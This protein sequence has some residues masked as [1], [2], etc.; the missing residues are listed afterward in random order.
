MSCDSIF[1]GLSINQDHKTVSGSKMSGILEFVQRFTHCWIEL[2][3]F[4]CSNASQTEV[5]TVLD[6][7]SAL[8][9]NSVKP[10]IRC[11]VSFIICD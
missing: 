3:R 2:Y 8:T 10:D 11:Y 1:Q 5:Q 4:G 9:L 6:R 7:L